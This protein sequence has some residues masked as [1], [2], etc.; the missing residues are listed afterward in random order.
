VKNQ[1]TVNMDRLR[2][3]TDTGGT[4]TPHGRK[5]FYSHRTGGPYYRWCDEKEPGQWHFSRVHPCV[6]T[7][8]ALHIT[9]LKNTPTAQRMNLKDAPT[10]LRMKLEEHYASV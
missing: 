3:Y 9:D 5:V 4:D 8:K 10:A 7:Y 2:I 1:K 6:S